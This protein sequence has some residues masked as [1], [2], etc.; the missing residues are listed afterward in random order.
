M[1]EWVCQWNERTNERTNAGLH[2]G[3]S[4]ISE[5]AALQDIG[6]SAFSDLPELLEL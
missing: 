6:A 5:N 4:F 3:P 1:R 2:L